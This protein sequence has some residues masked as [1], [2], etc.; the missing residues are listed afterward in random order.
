MARIYQ[1]VCGTFVI[2]ESDA[3]DVPAIEALGLR[4]V[5]TDILMPDHAARERLARVVLGAMA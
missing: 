2:H 3:D 5:V 4:A 1:D